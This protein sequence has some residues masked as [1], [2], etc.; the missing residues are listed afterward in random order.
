MKLKNPFSK[1]GGKI[2]ISNPF[3]KKDDKISIDNPF[4]KDKK[5]KDK[6][7][8][9]SEQ[10][11]LK[12]LY[13]E[14]VDSR[15]KEED[16]SDQLTEA[17]QN[18]YNYKDGANGYDQYKDIQ[19][20]IKSLSI[21]KHSKLTMSPTEYRNIELQA[22]YEAMIESKDNEDK[23]PDLVEEATK[24]YY[25]YKDGPDGYA[26]YQL[27]QY[28][29]DA[30]T[31]KKSMLTKHQEQMFIMN[32][33]IHYSESQQTYLKNLS[34]VT[35]T[36]A[37]K[38]KEQIGEV[39]KDSINTNNRKTYYTELA[40]QSLSNWTAIFNC[41]LVAFVLSLGYEYKNVINQPIIWGTLLSILIFT[42]SLRY[43]ISLLSKI[44]T[45]LSVYT[46]WGYDPNEP[47]IYWL[48]F[49]PIS[50]ILIY[51]VIRFFNDT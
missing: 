44:P 38:I 10:D 22:L 11:K 39:R 8:K 37:K 45:S 35:A 3:S 40:E 48:I 5:D 31:M 49:I 20:K 17:E 1:K 24:R 4:D 29:K 27:I 41:F 15:N 32:E 18:Y 28:N 33:S 21:Q 34:E 30:A 46:E 13:D 50:F 7:K 9:E 14:L 47:T 42:F 36:L 6:D 43:I 25:T 16:A 2:S 12:S 51:T 26:D 23:A 19:D